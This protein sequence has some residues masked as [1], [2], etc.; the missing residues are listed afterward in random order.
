MLQSSRKTNLFTDPEQ[1][2]YNIVIFN[3]INTRIA[4]MIFKLPPVN[5]FLDMSIPYIY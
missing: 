4:H 5:Y 3:I 2:R 1:D